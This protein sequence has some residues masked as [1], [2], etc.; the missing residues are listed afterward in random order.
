MRLP[1]LLTCLALAAAPCA[2]RAQAA[3]P[4][5]A[6]GAAPGSE[7]VIV[8]QVQR[9]ELWVPKYP[10]NDFSLGLYGGSYST[11]NFG[12]AG[13]AGLRLGYHVT[14]DLFFEASLGRS[15]V[16]DADFRQVL[17]GGIFPSGRETLSYAEV[18]AGYNALPGEVFI[19]RGRAYAT[20]GYVVLGLGSTKFASQTRQTFVGGFGLRLILGDH[21][22]LQADVRDHVYSLDLL[23]RLQ[24]TQNPELCLGLTAFF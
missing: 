12:S 13:V 15:R 17:P 23:G 9:R 1:L 24:S 10:S 2:S 7:Q 22:A 14:E 6:A 16:S 19:G 18:V 4:G 5:T 11:Q 8:P 20:Q 21:L 3:P